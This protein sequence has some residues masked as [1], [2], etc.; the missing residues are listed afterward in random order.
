MTPENLLEIFAQSKKP[1]L[2]TSEIY[3]IAKREYHVDDLYDDYEKHI[4]NLQQVLKSK[5]IIE[6]V[7]RGYWA[8]RA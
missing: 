5:G 1:M 8:L 6:N 7:K 3:D 4:R 2:S